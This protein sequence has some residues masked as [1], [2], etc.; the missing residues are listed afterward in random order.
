[1]LASMMGETEGTTETQ[2]EEWSG[3]NDAGT[4]LVVGLLTLVIGVVITVA[5]WPGTE[6]TGDI[7]GGGTVSETGSMPFAMVGAALAIVGQVA[8]TIGVIAFG[9]RIGTRP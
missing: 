8:T 6:V 9:V 4:L 3:K 5:A 1:M 2:A 7:L